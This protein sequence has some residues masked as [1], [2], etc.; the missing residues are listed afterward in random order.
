MAGPKTVDVDEMA[1]KKA[2]VRDKTADVI[3]NVSDRIRGKPKKVEPGEAERADAVIREATKAANG[4]FSSIDRELRVLIA[5]ENL[6]MGIS[7]GMRKR[8]ASPTPLAPQDT[9]QVLSELR[10]APQIQRFLVERLSRYSGEQYTNIAI[11]L[12][13]RKSIVHP[14]V[15]DG[16][17]LLETK[18]FFMNDIAALAGPNA[19][20]VRADL[21]A[22][23][24]GASAETK[25]DL[26]QVLF[27][28][29]AESGKI[30]SG[31]A[32]QGKSPEMERTLESIRR[33]FR[34]G[35]VDIEAYVR[36]LDGVLTGYENTITNPQLKSV[37]GRGELMANL[38][39]DLE[40]LA[41]VRGKLQPSEV[42]AFVSRDVNSAL[43]GFKN[44]QAMAIERYLAK[45]EVP[46]A[47]LESEPAIFKASL[48][49]DEVLSVVKNSAR[50]R[51]SIGKILPRF[52]KF[53]GMRQT[54]MAEKI[55]QG[56]EIEMGA[57]RRKPIGTIG[58]LVLLGALAF[59]GQQ[60]YTSFIVPMKVEKEEAARIFL[61]VRES[62]VYSALL[63]MS[64]AQGTPQERT[65]KDNMAYLLDP[66][67]RFIALSIINDGAYRT[68]AGTNPATMVEE[69]R[70]LKDTLSKND[71]LREMMDTDGKRIDA[72][73]KKE[74]A[75][76]PLLQYR[77]D[78]QLR[79]AKSDVDNAPIVPESSLIAENKRFVDANRDVWYWYNLLARE[80]IKTRP[81]LRGMFNPE[82]VNKGITGIRMHL[83]RMSPQDRK[84]QLADIKKDLVRITK[85]KI[86]RPKTSVTE[87]SK[88]L[89]ISEL[90]VKPE[91]EEIEKAE[92]AGGPLKLS[93]EAEAFWNSPANIMLSSL[94]EGAVND[95]LKKDKAIQSAL[96]SKYGGDR[97]KMD[98]AVKAEVYQFL[99]SQKGPDMNERGGY[100]IGI[101]GEGEDMSVDV[102]N[103]KLAVAGFR[104][105][106]RRFLLEL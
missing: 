38:R 28:S 47:L 83:E 4:F 97:E 91:E 25:I 68:L 15:I 2:G 62:E 71:I 13:L 57:L 86:E 17:L 35:G 37:L 5:R 29:P 60:I 56:E 19:N 6:S 41:H 81:E 89:G 10:E 104:G 8:L 74:A 31:G 3:E 16:S 43:Q 75:L 94:V 82:I 50:W 70:V 26:K 42:D 92:K 54:T 48:T 44:P 59:G 99:N 23:L 14:S 34:A 12:M 52:Q 106:I 88:L 80:S 76:G 24:R 36:E 77:V 84:G 72:T 102:Q 58:T 67:N 40:E 27:G 96:S 65:A 39:R 1:T 49:A 63:K 9:A 101:K 103:R 78:L 33:A 105:H 30:A 90:R 53:F 32:I 20:K 61:D 93:K 69:L 55:M 45:N 51:I 85:I 11:G 7:E 18:N 100:G 95:L 79:V 46:V 22:V 21:E 73:R 87:L 64:Q 98:S 66:K